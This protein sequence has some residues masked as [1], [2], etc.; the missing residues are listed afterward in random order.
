M[1]EVDH[2][3]GVMCPPP[4]IYLGVLLLGPVIDRL[5]GL[6]PLPIPGGFS[7][8]FLFP[9]FILIGIA[10]G[11]FRRRGENPNPAT[12]TSGIID[13]GIYARTRNPMYLGMA[14]AYLGL[15]ILLHSMPS[16]LLW[17][18]ALLLIRNQVIAREERY[19]TAKFG[20]PYLDYMARVKRWF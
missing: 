5:L 15:A 17:P 6:P 8:L 18:L 13:T 7:I 12:T 19:L 10:I 2:G 11:L 1:A 4:F 9:G 3:A 20:Q 16:L 14:I